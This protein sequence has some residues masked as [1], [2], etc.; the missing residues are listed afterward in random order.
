V[1]TKELW[2]PQFMGSDSGFFPSQQNEKKINFGFIILSKRGWE[3][4]RIYS[5][6]A[7]WAERGTSCKMFRTKDGKW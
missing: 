4:N 3:S 1:Q 7:M 6:G 2:K 5:A